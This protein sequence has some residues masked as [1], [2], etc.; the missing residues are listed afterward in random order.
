MSACLLATFQRVKAEMK[1]WRSLGNSQV[2]TNNN[3]FTSFIWLMF[4]L[5][6]QIV[7]LWAIFR[8]YF[9]CIFD[10]HVHCLI[11]ENL[12]DVIIYN[13]ADDPK[14]KNRGFAF[15]EYDSHKSASVA[16][17]KLGNGRQRVWN[18]D[19]IVDWADPQEEPD[20]ETMS[21]VWSYLGFFVDIA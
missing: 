4:P 2:L 5:S 6:M 14:K 11:S 21:K 18:C 10:K 1:S 12:T 13:V 7:F 3:F 19:I 20:Q 15:L 8:I 16:K 9:D 17:R